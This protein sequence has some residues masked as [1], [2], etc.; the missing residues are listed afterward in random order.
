MVELQTGSWLDNCSLC[1][2]QLNAEGN[3]KITFA[4]GSIGFRASGIVSGGVDVKM[5]RDYQC[6][7]LLPHRELPCCYLLF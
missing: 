2:A 3:P 1:S 4:N 6:Q 7:G 5:P